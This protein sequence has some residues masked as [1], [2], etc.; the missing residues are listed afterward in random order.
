M[1]LP[2][3]QKE[4]IPI[5]ILSIVGFVWNLI[6][7]YIFEKFASQE[8]WFERSIVEFGNSTGVAASGLLLL[9]LVDPLNVSRTLPVFSIKQ[10]FL[11]K[12]KK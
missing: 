8:E 9:R 7:I 3:I 1:N 5:T 2:L 10:L 4:W 11:Q 12:T 6:G